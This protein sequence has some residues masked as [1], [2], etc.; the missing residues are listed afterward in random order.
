M[1]R[2]DILAAAR[3][4]GMKNEEY[5][6]HTLLRGDNLSAAIGMLLGMILFLAEW[7]VKKEMNIGLAT[8]FFTMSAIQTIYEGV[9]L[10]KKI[11]IIVGIF[12]AVLAVLSLLLFIGL[13]VIA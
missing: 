5:E 4:N 13:M 3:E 11:C 8:M 9:K 7:F 10:H 2:E 1:N 12:I 6:K